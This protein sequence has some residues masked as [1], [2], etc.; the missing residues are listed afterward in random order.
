MSFSAD[1][2]GV[3]LSNGG[4]IPPGKYNLRITSAKE[5]L[6][7]KGD[8]M[9][10]VDYEV[11]D[12][13]FA[14]RKVKY[15]C[16][17]FFNDKSQKGAWVSKH[18]LKMIGLPYDGKIEVDSTKWIGRCVV[19]N[20]SMQTWNDGKEHASVKSVEKYDVDYTIPMQELSTNDEEVPF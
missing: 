20:V 10:V 19:G 13:S 1:F 2:D 16:V 8:P 4:E 15:H 9:V 6:T 5:K 12:G 7:K 18:Y 17:V 14:G 3:E 11:I